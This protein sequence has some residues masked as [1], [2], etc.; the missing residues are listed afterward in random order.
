M[1]QIHAD[2]QKGIF[3]PKHQTLTEKDKIRLE[4]VNLRARLREIEAT[5]Y[6]L[7]HSYQYLK[8]R[9]VIDWDLHFAEI[10]TELEAEKARLENNLK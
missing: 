8:I 1:S 3:R 7:R 9:K 2:L 6:A 5:V 10:K 4:V